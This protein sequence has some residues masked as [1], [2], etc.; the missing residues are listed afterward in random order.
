[1]RLLLVLLAAALVAASCAEFTKAPAAR[2]PLSE[3]LAGAET[4]KIEDATRDCL[5]KGGWKVDRYPSQSAGVNVI[6]AYKAKDQTD[7]YVHPPGTK[8]RVTGGPDDADPFWTCL[9]ASLR[10][11]AADEDAGAPAARP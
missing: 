7:V 5:T 1:M 9:G 10:G 8:P 11:A 6:T 4:P 2:S 3:Q